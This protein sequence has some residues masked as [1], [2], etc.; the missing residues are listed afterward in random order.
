MKQSQMEGACR[1][2]MEG[3]VSRSKWPIRVVTDRF[4]FFF[5][6]SLSLFFF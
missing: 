5:F 2:Q 6:F 1:R 4:I 3:G